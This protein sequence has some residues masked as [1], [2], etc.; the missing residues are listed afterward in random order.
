MVAVQVVQI[1]RRRALSLVVAGLFAITGFVSVG[2]VGP[3]SS[4]AYGGYYCGRLVD[5][6][7]G[8]GSSNRCHESSSAHTWNWNESAYQG[9]LALRNT[10]AAI[11]PGY[12]DAITDGIYG[13]GCA[14]YARYYTFCHA[15]VSYTYY[16]WLAQSDL[17]NR[18]TMDGYALTGADCAT[19]GHGLSRSAAATRSRAR[20]VLP[21]GVAG[22]GRGVKGQR[23]AA[24]ANAVNRNARRSPALDAASGRQVGPTAD[25]RGNQLFLLPGKGQSCVVL[26][27]VQDDADVT[28]CGSSDGSGAAPGPGVTVTSGGYLVWGVVPDGVSDVRVVADGSEIH[29][30]VSKNGFMARSE[31]W[32]ESVSWVDGSGASQTTS[33]EAP[34]GR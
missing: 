6:Y 17:G 18:H 16:A 3:S 19:Q 27:L 29:V 20:Q 1:S 2:L 7:F 32:P 23:L 22:Y 4:E 26:A 14:G 15:P 21:L 10:C 25:D 12:N 24:I 33:L 28:A 30:P 11:T 5:D 13:S 9:T 8:G 31:R 34:S